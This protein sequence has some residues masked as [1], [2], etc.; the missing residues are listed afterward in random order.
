MALGGGREGIALECVERAGISSETEL[1]EIFIVRSQA[2]TNN[3]LAGWR[4]FTLDVRV[5][6][7]LLNTQRVVDRSFR[8]NPEI[9]S[10][11]DESDGSDQR[12]AGIIGV[13]LFEKRTVAGD[14]LE[15]RS[16][17]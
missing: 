9:V 15:F 12:L 4:L 14:R 16:D 6:K 10:F 1:D 5:K 8:V 11:R 3:F 13:E 7:L 17:G 2:G